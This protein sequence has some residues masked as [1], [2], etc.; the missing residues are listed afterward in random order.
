MF[1]Q[2]QF[3]K[4]D[5]M[6]HFKLVGNI[7]KA[8]VFTNRDWRDISKKLKENF[9]FRSFELSRSSNRF[10]LTISDSVLVNTNTSSSKR[11]SLKCSTPFT[12]NKGMWICSVSFSQYLIVP[13]T[14]L[15]YEIE[16]LPSPVTHLDQID[17]FIVSFGLIEKLSYPENHHIGWDDGS[18]GY[19]SDDGYLFHENGGGERFGPTF[20]S[21]DVVGV[22]FIPRERVIF[23]TNNGT[24]IKNRFIKVTSDVWYPAIGFSTAYSVQVNFGKKPFTFNLLKEMQQH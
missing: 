23:F 2:N 12:T 20:N 9:I 4:N 5:L 22:G 7:D 3:I 15:Y 11:V 24:I 17:E 10:G 16:I 8:P 1:S 13:P 14:I 19:H 6:R 21:G 18:I